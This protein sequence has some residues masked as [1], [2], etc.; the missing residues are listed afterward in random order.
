[1]ANNNY[2]ELSK[3]AQFIQHELSKKDISTRVIE[4]SESTRT[5]Q[6]AA[7]AI[8]C[9]I[10]QIVKSLIFRTKQTDRPILVL[11]TGPNKVNVKALETYIGESLE[12]A[13]ANF[14]R[15]V[16]GFA[17]GGIPP[18]GH[19]EQIKT[20]IDEDLFKHE[21]LWA[22]AGTPHAVFNIRSKDLELLTQG[23][24]VSIQ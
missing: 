22:A 14:T 16:T 19:K 1:M 17:I 10:G 21:E 11:A 12:K 6:D 2:Q 23:K 8:G 18:I 24:V 9:S 3:S 4:L 15:D 13:D 20:F 7:H 5:A